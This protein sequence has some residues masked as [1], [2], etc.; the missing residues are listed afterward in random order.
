ME[1]KIDGDTMVITVKL[2]PKSEAPFSS[3]GKTRMLAS[4]GGFHRMPDGKMV[5]LMVCEKP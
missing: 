1:I 3:S 2:L 4:T 5:N